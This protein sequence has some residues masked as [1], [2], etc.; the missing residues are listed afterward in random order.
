[1]TD[2]ELMSLNK[3]DELQSNFIRNVGHELRTP[4]TI[5]QGFANLL[6][7]G[8]LGELDP[9]QQNATLV[10][11]KR[12]QEL[13]TMVE[14]INL[15]LVLEGS[16]PLFRPL[17][18]ANLVQ[19]AIESRIQQA[20]QNNL[21][22]ELKLE[23]D[24]PSIGGDLYHLDHAIGCLIE[25]ALKF[26]PGG[27]KIRV[28]VSTVDDEWVELQVSDTG[29]GIPEEQLPYL[30]D[31][32]CQ[33]DGSTTRRYGGIGL[34]LNVIRTVVESHN[35]KIELQSQID[36][37]SCFTLKFPIL[38]SME[39]LEPTP[40]QETKVRRILIVD[41]EERITFML[42]AGLKKL[43]NC[44]VVATTS[45]EEAK[46]LFNQETFDLLITDYK[47]PDIDGISLAKYIRQNHAHTSIVMITAYGDNE[48]L[49][50]EADQALIEQI[51]DKPVR[52]QEIRELALE[53]LK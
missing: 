3:L 25:N 36:V 35:G 51:L 32:L 20:E 28:T 4:L 13:K 27:G 1:M 50:E 49:R 19:D 47:M 41:D 18:L 11:M 46:H 22:L 7:D 34:G 39:E 40:E 8:T 5:I 14:R 2:R 10:I 37:G 53:M 52:L 17:N 15:L 42:R 38:T 6:A 30:F 23:K 44:E 43:H 21:T 45:G 9:D 26:T 33:G 29:I 48:D 24:V 31:F 12:T 16:E